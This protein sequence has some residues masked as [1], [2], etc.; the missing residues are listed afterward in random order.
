MCD[1]LVFTVP[2]QSR[3]H[4]PPHPLSL[5]LQQLEKA[6]GRYYCPAQNLDGNKI[7]N[8]SRVDFP[9]TPSPLQQKTT[10]LPPDI[11]F[12]DRLRERRCVDGDN[13]LP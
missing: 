2:C 12:C 13:F 7:V 6:K 5:N 9:E 10:F 1:F 11:P 4:T 8:M 3:S